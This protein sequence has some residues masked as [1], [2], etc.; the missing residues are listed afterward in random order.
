MK[1]YI[2]AMLI[3]AGLFACKNEDLEKGADKNQQTEISNPEAITYKLSIAGELEK[4]ETDLSRIKETDETVYYALQVYQLD[5]FA[6]INSEWGENYVQNFGRNNYAWAIFD[7]LDSI[8]INLLPNKDYRFDMT[9]YHS[10]TG[11][12]LYKNYN[13]ILSSPHSGKKIKN[14][15]NYSIDEKIDPFYN[16]ISYFDSENNRITSQYPEIEAYVGKRYID[17]NDSLASQTINIDLYKAFY[18]AR[19][20]IKNLTEG[21]IKIKHNDHEM[22]FDSD[23]TTNPRTI[24]YD[25]YSVSELSIFN[26]ST[27]LNKNYRNNVNVTKIHESGIEEVLFNDRLNFK[28]NKLTTYTITA[29]SGGQEP[30]GKGGFS[31]NYE[32]TPMEEIDGGEIINQE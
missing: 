24:S 32:I 21:Q 29:P 22:I 18:G 6:I 11:K 23:T 17:L 3:T 8:E 4:N 30:N 26:D 7:N 5:S 25:L 2:Y 19:F 27:T 10:G 12:N 28:R 15:I 20:T 14:S 1:K 13:N 31:I 9:A 16:Y